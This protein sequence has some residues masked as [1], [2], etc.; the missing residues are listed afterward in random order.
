MEKNEPEAV[1]EF[2]CNCKVRVVHKEDVQDFPWVTDVPKYCLK[3][4]KTISMKDV[5]YTG[6]N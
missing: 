3:C 6:D 5:Y 2:E 1:I 4:H